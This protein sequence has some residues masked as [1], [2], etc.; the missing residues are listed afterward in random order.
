MS[1]RKVPN[2]AN[3]E[4]RVGHLISLLERLMRNQIS[5]R[6][7]PLDI[8]LQQYVTLLL[9]NSRGPMSNAELARASFIT[10]QSANKVVKLLSEKDYVELHQ[11][12][13]HR[14]ILLI[15]LT[16]GGEKLFQRADDAVAAVEHQLLDGFAIEDRKQFQKLLIEGVIALGEGG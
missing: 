9:L 4:I 11:N 3:A 13:S 5:S 12:P 8:T 2:T 15:H 16:K 6:L 7:A 14:R 1:T 10:P